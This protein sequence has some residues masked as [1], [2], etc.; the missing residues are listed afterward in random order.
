MQEPQGRVPGPKPKQLVR[1]A[2]CSM[3]SA[4]KRWAPDAVVECYGY[5]YLC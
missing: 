3:F 4:C 1:V 2:A 5:E